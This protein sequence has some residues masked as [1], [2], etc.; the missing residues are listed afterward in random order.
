MC[1]REEGKLSI[2]NGSF[3]SFSQSHTSIESNELQI[4]TLL[5]MDFN[6]GKENKYRRRNL[7]IIIGIYPTGFL[8]FND[9]LY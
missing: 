3:F 8:P 1:M 9:F 6:S 2:K 4:N 5:E 7:G